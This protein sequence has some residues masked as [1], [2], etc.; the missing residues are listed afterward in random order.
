[1]TPTIQEEE[2]TAGGT[3]SGAI[4][5]FL[6][7]D[8]MTGRG[9]DQVMP[10]PSVP[11]LYESYV[12]DA[13]D[14]VALAEERNGPIRKP[15]SFAY[16]W[17]DALAALEQAAPDVRLINLETSITTSEE[18]WPDKGIH[19]RMHPANIACLTSA[20]ID[21][22]ALANNH[23]LDW[24]YPGLRETL[25]TLQSVGIATAGLG[26]RL[27]LARAPAVL[28]VG[29]KGRVV[30]FSFGEEGSGVPPEWAAG[31]DR[32]GVDFLPDLSRSTAREIG[33]R[34]RSVKR[35]GD[36][37]V[38]SIHWGGNWGYPISPV[39]RAFAHALIDEAQVDVIHGH[40]SHHPRG[41]E[42]HRGRLILYGCGD[43]LNDYEG[44]HGYEA[45]RGDLTL[46]YFASV[47]PASGRLVS[48][49]MLPMQLHRLRLN[50]A[51]SRDAQWL[52][53]MLDREGHALGTRAQLEPDGALTLR[54]A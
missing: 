29:A 22:C 47:E 3:A 38:A 7:G 50:P 53:Q 9:I 48:L 1:M 10:H 25:A 40:S 33:E 19:Y 32:P 2:R 44:I 8:V 31:V 51:S 30:V 21:C 11:H 26:E 17:G 5:L 54:W 43:F 18:W 41:I 52:C 49:R 13:R 45:F 20:R 23:V 4:S 24:G 6:C 12:R 42:V 35:V 27:E 16:I 39:Q 14:Y 15:V 34:V 46:M 28:G 36:I 37:V